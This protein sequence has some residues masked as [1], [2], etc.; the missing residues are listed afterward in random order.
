MPQYIVE[1][2]SIRYQSLRRDLPHLWE[3]IRIIARQVG[4]GVRGTVDVDRRLSRV[5]LE[6]NDTLGQVRGKLMRDILPADT[7]WEALRVSPYSDALEELVSG[8]FE[9][10]RAV[11]E[12]LGGPGESAW[13]LLGQVRDGRA[14]E[15]FLLRGGES[16]P[17]YRY[18]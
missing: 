9:S 11:V 5:V 3:A 14:A 18:D 16:E 4:A 13:V 6:V 15:V 17:K 2:D 8:E 12:I 7:D 10:Q 1:T